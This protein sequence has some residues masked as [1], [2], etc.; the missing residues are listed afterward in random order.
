MGLDNLSDELRE[1]AQL[2][3]DNIDMSLQEIGETLGEPIS[4]SGVNHRFKKLAKMAEELR[5][6]GTIN[7]K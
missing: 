4:R 7:E 1:V 5:M 2:R 6:G 3:L